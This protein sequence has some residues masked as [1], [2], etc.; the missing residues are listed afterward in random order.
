MAIPSL[1]RAEKLFEGRPAF[2]AKLGV[3]AST[4]GMWH[5]R[6]NIPTA[7]LKEIEDAAAGQVTVYELLADIEALRR[8]PGG[9]EATVA[10]EAA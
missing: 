4:V 7:Y 8:Q 6:G 3:S 2:A 9:P 5:N 10:E 1:S